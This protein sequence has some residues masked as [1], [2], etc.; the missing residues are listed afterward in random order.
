MI[1]PTWNKTRTTNASMLCLAP[2]W[3]CSPDRGLLKFKL[4]FCFFFCVFGLFWCVDI[5]IEFLKIKTLFCCISQQKAL[6]KAT[7]TTLSNT[8]LV[9]CKEIKRL[10]VVTRKDLKKKVMQTVVNEC[11]TIPNF[12]PTQPHY[13][14][15]KRLHN[16]QNYRLGQPALTSKK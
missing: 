8:P 11:H 15:Q 7:I 1:S 12:H 4:F 9:T 14:S 13:W 10:N 3:K 2:V 5:K 16:L 6:W